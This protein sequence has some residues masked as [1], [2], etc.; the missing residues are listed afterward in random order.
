MKI[1]FVLNL[2]IEYDY[3]FIHYYFNFYKIQN[4]IISKTFLKNW[5]NKIQLIYKYMN[6][7]N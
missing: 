7:E 1:L 4:K 6:F 3:F 2:K 5:E